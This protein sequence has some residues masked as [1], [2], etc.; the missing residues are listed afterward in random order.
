MLDTSANK[1]VERGRQR[2]K[3]VMAVLSEGRTVT[4]LARDWEVSRQTIHGWLARYE[5]EGMEGM[6]D[7]PHRPMECQ[8]ST[9]S[10]SSSRKCYCASAP[11]E[12]RAQDLL[13]PAF[14]RGFAGTSW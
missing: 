12:S 8:G 14:A 3:A 4:E 9:E 7:R 5:R 13:L 1:T 6:G 11:Y 10:F 2:Y